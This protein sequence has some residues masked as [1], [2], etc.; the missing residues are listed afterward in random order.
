EDPRD[1]VQKGGR[2]FARSQAD[3]DPVRLNGGAFHAILAEG[4]CFLA[5]IS[6]SVSRMIASMTL[7]SN[8]FGM[9]RTCRG[10][11]GNA[12]GCPVTTT[13]LVSTISWT[14]RITLSPVMRGM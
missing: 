5:R 11:F 3:S 9:K 1:V 2:R 14:M 12:S 7:K 6:C 10:G 4:P 8:G 13:K